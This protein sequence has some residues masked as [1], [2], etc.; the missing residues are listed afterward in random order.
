MTTTKR[1][2]VAATIAQ[3]IGAVI[4]LYVLWLIIKALFLS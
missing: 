2:N 3:I 1:G 4:M